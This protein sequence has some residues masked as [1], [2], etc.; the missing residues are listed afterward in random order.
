MSTNNMVF[1]EKYKR[2]TTVN[3]KDSN[4][5]DLFTVLNSNSFLRP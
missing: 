1:S 4:T 3:L 5:D 2:Y